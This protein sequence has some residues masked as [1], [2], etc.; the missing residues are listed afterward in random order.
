MLPLPMIS[1]EHRRGGAVGLRISRALAT[2]RPDWLACE[3]RAC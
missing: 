1:T 2:T 3:L